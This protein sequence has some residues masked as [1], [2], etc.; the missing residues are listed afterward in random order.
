MCF[1]FVVYLA[2]SQAFLAALTY[3]W[4]SSN[5]FP[6]LLFPELF[7]W[8]SFC[9]F[10][11][12]ISFWLLYFISYSLLHAQTYSN[13]SSRYYLSFVLWLSPLLDNGLNQLHILSW[14][15]CLLFG[16]VSCF[17]LGVG[18]LYFF[19]VCFSLVNFWT[20]QC[21]KIFVIRKL[22]MVQVYY[23]SAIW[24][25]IRI[26]PQLHHFFRGHILLYRSCHPLQ[27]IPTICSLGLVA[28]SKLPFFPLSLSFGPYA[29]NIAISFIC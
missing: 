24:I 28:L 10:S 19:S 17:Q 7:V 6:T 12:S 23:S 9:L 1:L 3:L 16:K 29:K 15:V 8:S 2:I 27:C 13:C 11:F 26:Y 14:L 21:W 25:L 18:L 4:K 22:F 5:I 20:S